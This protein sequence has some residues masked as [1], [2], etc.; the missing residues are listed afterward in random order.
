MPGHHLFAAPLWFKQN[1]KKKRKN[2]VSEAVVVLGQKKTKK[3]I[4]FQWFDL[5]ESLKKKNKKIKIKKKKN[6]KKIKK[7]KEKRKTIKKS[8]KKI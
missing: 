8:M 3:M 4:F 5:D 7:K 1:K 6:K 2:W